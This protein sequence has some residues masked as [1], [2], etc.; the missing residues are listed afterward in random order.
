MSLYRKTD[1]R[2]LQRERERDIEFKK[3][4]QVIVEAGKSEICR[5]GQQTGHSAK[6]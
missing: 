4:A 2:Y 3:L 5:A 1:D 6:S